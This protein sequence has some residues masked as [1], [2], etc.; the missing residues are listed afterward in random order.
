MLITKGVRGAV[1]AGAI[2]LL[3]AGCSNEKPEQSQPIDPPPVSAEEMMNRLNENSAV[4]TSAAEQ[5]EAATRVTLYYKSDQGYV[6]PVTLQVPN[7]ES[8]AKQSL[9]FMVKGGPGEA[10]LPEGFQAL[11]PEG[12]K[13]T[14]DIGD[15][16]LA[17]VDFSREFLN[18]DEADERKILEAITWTLT[19]FPT[20]DQVELSVNG[21]KLTETPTG[22]PLNGSLTRKMGIN[23]EVASGVEIGRSTP[24]TLY[25]LNQTNPEQAYYVPV[26]RLVERTAE[27]E[28]A[29]KALQELV[30]AP[31][32]Y[33]GLVSVLNA[34]AQLLDLS[35]SVDQ[36]LL[37]VNFDEGLLDANDYVPAAAVQSVVLSLTENTGADQV[38]IL[39]NGEGS[40]QTEEQSLAEP[41]SRPV[42]VN[43]VAQ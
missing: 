18:Y 1:L 3:A 14:V 21:E 23:L 13:L 33:K 31:S 43:T 22:L 42:H 41:V 5:G 7:T 24:V 8:I 11:L 27:E 28:L 17:R 16:K 2:V 26:T 29:G 36:E 32:G 34:D 4:E 9:E 40:I 39:V 15:D 35:Q 38:Q 20:I 37:T 10:Y 30:K 19:G 6:A 12:T 25:F